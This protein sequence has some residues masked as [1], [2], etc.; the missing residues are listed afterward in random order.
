MRALEK[1]RRNDPNWGEVLLLPGSKSIDIDRA[2]AD[3]LVESLDERCLIL[4]K[5][6][7]FYRGV[8]LF[9]LLVLVGVPVASTGA[10]ILLGA[11]FANPSGALQGMHPIDALLFSILTLAFALLGALG[12]ACMM[13][14]PKASPTFFCRAHRKVY[15]SSGLT[16]WGGWVELNFDRLTAV[17]VI[18]RRYHQAGRTTTYS[19]WLCEIDESDRIS[20]RIVAMQPSRLHDTPREAWEF[21]RAY[22]NLPPEEV[23]PVKLAPRGISWAERVYAV[24]LRLFGA[25]IDDK[26]HR[27]AGPFSSVFAL[28]LGAITYPWEMTG[29]VLNRVVR[30]R[31]PP[32]ELQTLLSRSVAAST[33]YRVL[34]G[35]T[36]EAI[37]VQDVACAD[38][39]THVLAMAL[40]VLLYGAMVFFWMRA[41]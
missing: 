1:I 6:E 2:N 27:L 14:V 32:D 7:P 15:G 17:S 31:T 18:E 13:L 36:A 11:G 29:W 26:T 5:W 37:R 39:R 24:N 40:S 30:A 23:P 12:A 3:L 34:E 33:S 10:A 25:L 38:G 21:I 22:M 19:L 20:K 35:N 16:G 28:L 9:L 4:R 41:N 8:G